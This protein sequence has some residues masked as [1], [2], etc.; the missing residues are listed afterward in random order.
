MLK[1]F[2]EADA[3]GMRKCQ[4]VNAVHSE[5][6]GPGKHGRVEKSGEIRNQC[7]EKKKIGRN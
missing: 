4:K 5:G 7:V 3:G 1:L 6:V 2:H